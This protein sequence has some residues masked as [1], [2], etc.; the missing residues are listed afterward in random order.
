MSTLAFVFPGQGAQYVG[1]GSQLAQEF[2]EA[3]AVFA[4]ADQVMGYSLSTI[5]FQGP[6]EDLNRTEVTQPAILTASYA[7]FKVLQTHGLTPAYAAGLSLGEYSALVASGSLDFASA[8]KLVVRRGHLMQDAVPAGKGQ[9][10]AVLGLERQAVEAA[11]R[12]VED[13]TG[14]VVEVANYNC[15]GQ[16]VLSGDKEAV[17]QAGEIV[18][19]AG[20][21]FIPLA[22]SV[23]SHCRLMKEA[24]RQLDRELT[25]INWGQGDCTVVSNALGREAAGESTVDLLVRQLYSPVLWEQTIKFLALR[26]DYFVEVGPGRV[27][28]ALIR[29]TAGRQLLGNVDDPAGYEKIVAKLQEV[30]SHG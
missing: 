16:L 23:P 20:A 4:E 26:V 19:R 29:K 6:A 22:V 3:R 21:K 30:S 28:S 1:M 24:A 13:I 7:A 5:C 11:C 9:M 8:L 15:P 27:L 17:L 25:M 14:K 10:A 12:E 2:S 18:Q